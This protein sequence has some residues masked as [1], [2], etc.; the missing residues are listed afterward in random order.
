MLTMKTGN[1]LK[2]KIEVLV[3]PVCEDKT[4][5]VDKAIEGLV[6]GVKKFKEFGG[7]SG[8][9]I[10]LYDPDGVAAKRVVFA[11]LGKVSEL[12]AEVLR[13]FAGKTVKKCIEKKFKKVAFIVPDAKR[14]KTDFNVAAKSM[15]EGACLGNYIFDTFITDKKTKVLESIEF[16]VDSKEA[17]KYKGLDE[18]VEK[19]CSGTHLAREWVSSPS[20]SKT[21]EQFVETLKGAFKKTSVKFSLLKEDKLKKM[22]CGALLSVSRGSKS[23]AFMAVADY[24]PEKAKKTIALV[25][26]GV[27]FDSGGINLKTAEGLISMKCDMAGAAT[28]A[29]VVHTLEA[30]KADVRVIGVMPVVENMPS[31]D[32][33]RPGDIVTSLNGK[34]IE[35]G[36]T[37]AEGRLILADALSYTEK[38]YKPD[39]IIDLATLTGACVMALGEKIAGVFSFNDRL[40]GKIAK[41][42]SKTGERCWQMPMPKDYKKLLKSEFADLSNM[43]NTRMGGAITAAL[44]LSEFVK[45]KDWAHVDIAGPAYNMK[46]EDYCVPGGTGFGVRL[47][48]DFLVPV[49]P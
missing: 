46:P 24:N 32:A 5:Y 45:S 41:S 11:G 16:F 17:K 10:I 35:I 30:I 49:K 9:E 8:D 47:L 42:G 6:A 39:V 40:A 1:P 44:F 15:F 27:T 36:N 22:G 28:V 2:R 26:K 4:V 3:V 37:D 48:C 31:G 7:K 12:D 18:Q 19:I 34:T 23:P 38:E 43:P 21:P 14:L 33:L 13:A 29:A 25:G 20:N